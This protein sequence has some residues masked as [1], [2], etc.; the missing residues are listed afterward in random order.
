[1]ATWYDWCGATTSTATVT[2]TNWC[3]TITT[4]TTASTANPIWLKWSINANGTDTAD[5]A[6]VTWVTSG[7][8]TITS[9]HAYQP[10]VDTRT[11][12]QKAADDARIAAERAEIQ[13]KAELAAAERRAAIERARALLLSM[14]TVQEREQYQ[15][16]QFFDVIAKHSKRRYRIRQGSHGNVR[17][18]DAAGREVASY[19]GQP[20]GVP[21]EDS[22]LAQK[23]QIEHDEDEF[24]RH[25]N[26]R[27]LTA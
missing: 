21:T 18:L 22:M 5:T 3:Q 9:G 26:R 11:P 19:C 10:Y 4:A 12:E 6:W 25:A 14:L 27:A 24:L 17:L 13:R 16:E 15:R 1:M 8:T 2:W 20:N 7:T 23:L